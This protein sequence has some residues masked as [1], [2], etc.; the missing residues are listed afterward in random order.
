[1]K[2]CHL[3][4][5]LSN[6]LYIIQKAKKILELKMDIPTFYL[7]ATLSRKFEINKSII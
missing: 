5:K 4:K 3:K 7:V 6:R 1:M 2:N